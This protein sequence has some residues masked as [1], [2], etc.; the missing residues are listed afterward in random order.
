MHDATQFLDPLAEPSEFLFA[1]PVVL[2]IA[3]LD[4][5]FLELLEHRALLSIVAGPDIGQ[6]PVEPFGLGAQEAEIVNVR[7]LCRAAHYAA[8]AQNG[9]DIRRFWGNRLG[10]VLRFFPAGSWEEDVMISSFGDAIGR[11]R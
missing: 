7:R 6:A 2:G 5:G 8:W 9:Q 10:I 3:R 4:I 11:V 1:D